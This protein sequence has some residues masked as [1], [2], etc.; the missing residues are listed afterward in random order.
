LYVIQKNYKCDGPKFPPIHAFTLQPTPFVLPPNSNVVHILPIQPVIQ[1]PPPFFEPI[2]IH[3]LSP[4]TKQFDHDLLEDP[5]D[6]IFTSIPRPSR[7]SSSL[8]CSIRTLKGKTTK[9]KDYFANLVTILDFEIDELTIIH[10][11]LI[12]SKGEHWKK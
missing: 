10:E 1:T 2:F 3:T 4:S 6:Q 7:I 12:N 5:F 9:Y 11:A 8:Q